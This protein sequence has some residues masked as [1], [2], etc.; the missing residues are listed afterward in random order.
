MSRILPVNLSDLLGGHRARTPFDDRLAR[1][2]SIEDLR[3]WKVREHLKEAESTLLDEPDAHRI[4][5]RMRIVG[6]ANGYAVPRNVGLLLFSADPCEWFR[7]ARIEVARFADDRAGDVQDERIFKGGLIEQVRDALVYLDNMSGTIVALWSGSG[8]LSSRWS[9]RT[10][11]RSSWRLE[12]TASEPIC[13][14]TNCVFLGVV[15]R[16]EPAGKTPRPCRNRWRDLAGHE[17]TNDNPNVT[18]GLGSGSHGPS[19]RPASRCR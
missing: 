11:A 2:A 17:T 8:V 19:S 10:V 3:E 5:R 7:G 9:R 1:D 15:A 14:P 12:K 16:G 4:F 13:T 6:A 18:S